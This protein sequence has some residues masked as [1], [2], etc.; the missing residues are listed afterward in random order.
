MN[1]QTLRKW[2]WCIRFAVF[3]KLKARITWTDAYDIAKC[4]FEDNILYPCSPESRVYEELS[5]WSE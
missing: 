2:I 5:Y 4:Y 3:M 1:T